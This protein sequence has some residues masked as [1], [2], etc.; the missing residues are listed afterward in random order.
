MKAVPRIV[1]AALAPAPMTELAE[2]LAPTLA[3]GALEAPAMAPEGMISPEEETAPSPLA[4]AAALAPTGI[5]EIV[6]VEEIAAP[7]AAPLE[8]APGALSLSL[9]L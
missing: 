9:T 5:E 8:A 3:P 6:V 4:E 7:A 2:V 1:A